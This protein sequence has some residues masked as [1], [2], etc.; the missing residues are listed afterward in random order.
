MW[1]GSSLDAYVHQEN[2]REGV[3]VMES[4][5]VYSVSYSTASIF[6]EEAK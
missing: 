5:C 1:P 4:N 3:T 2:Q 6:F